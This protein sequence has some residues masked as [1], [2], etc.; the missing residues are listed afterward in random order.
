MVTNGKWY[1]TLIRYLIIFAVLVVTLVP[2]YV[3]VSNSFRPTLQIHEMP[4]RII[5]TPTLSHYAG[6]FALDNFL[7]YFRNSAIIAVTATAITLILG[8]FAA[9]ALKLF[10]SRLGE[11]ISNFM[12]LGKLVP[13]ITI[14]LPLFVMLNRVRLTGTYVGPILAHSAISLP[15]VMWLMA[16][17]VRDLPGELLESARLEGATR[18]QTFWRVVFPLLMPALASAVVLVMQASWNELM[19]SLQLTNIHTYPLTVGIA[20]YVGAVSVDWGKSSVAA[21]VAMAP[22][23]A[24]GF[25]MQ[26]YLVTGMTAGAV[27]T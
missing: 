5:F 16:G 9:Y 11:R 21:T 2:V 1:I 7:D 4:P 8:S 27:K 18:M 19:F 12:L 20:R 17:F 15:F 26:R 13:S 22:I 24:I 10:R 14:L 23:V 25:L 6:V 3:V